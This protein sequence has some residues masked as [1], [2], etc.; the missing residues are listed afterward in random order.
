MNRDR[1]RDLLKRVADGSQTPDEAVL[2][3]T[4]Q[5]FEDL[6]YAHVDTHRPLRTSF[7]E[8]VFGQGKT[9]DQVAGIAQ[10]IAA[11]GYPVLV[12]KV[13]FGVFEVVA[14]A[15]PTACYHEE[16]RM[17]TVPPTDPPK[18]RGNVTVVSGG[19]SDFP[20][21]EEA[22]VTAEALG[23]AVVRIPDAG[24]A[25]LHRLLAHRESLYSANAIVAVAGMEGA[26][27]SVIGGLVSCPVIAV[28]T[29][30]GYGSSFDGLAAL[31]AMLNSCTPGVSVVNIDNGFG[32]GYQAALIAQHVAEGA[33][34]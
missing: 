3:L 2:E 18:T 13:T 28:P 17:I 8:V 30:V 20:V 29:S 31:L 1:V 19:T 23:A 22:A 11:T 6:G 34:A 21:S 5:P 26:L 12:T 16:A 33:G 27:P 10:R 4:Y 14:A 25:G 7:P 9:A 24:V 32:G 15:L